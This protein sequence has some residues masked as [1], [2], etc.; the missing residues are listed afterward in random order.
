M[1][2]L[3]FIPT[4]EYPIQPVMKKAEF[5]GSWFLNFMCLCCDFQDERY[6]EMLNHLQTVHGHHSKKELD[7]LKAKQ[8]QKMITE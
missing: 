7:E 6:K 5:D 3:P 1:R 2:V 4:L 8:H